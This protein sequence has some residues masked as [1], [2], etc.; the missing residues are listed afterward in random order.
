MARAA[1]FADA[2]HQPQPLATFTDTLWDGATTPMLTKSSAGPVRAGT[3]RPSVFLA[4]ATCRSTGPPRPLA[5]SARFN[6]FIGVRLG[7]GRRGQ[8]ASSLPSG[9]RPGLPWFPPANASDEDELP[10]ASSPVKGPVLHA[11]GDGG[12]HAGLPGSAA[13]PSSAAGAESRS[14]RTSRVAACPG[15]GIEPGL[16][17]GRERKATGTCTF[18]KTEGVLWEEF[19]LPV[20]IWDTRGY[21]EVTR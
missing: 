9:L 21:S 7:T 6:F 16:T 10:H 1:A 2:F 12:G 19:V 18:G 11:E 4:T 15:A 8:A 13:F 14:A 3:P 17:N 20:W 5:A